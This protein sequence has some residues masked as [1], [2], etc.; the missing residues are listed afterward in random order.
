MIRTTFHSHR[1]W[2]YDTFNTIS[3]GMLLLLLCIRHGWN[4]M[5]VVVPV[6]KVTD[7][8]CTSGRMDYSRMVPTQRRLLSSLSSSSNRWMFRMFWWRHPHQYLPEPFVTSTRLYSTNTTNDVDDTTTSIKLRALASFI[9]MNMFESMLTAGVP[10][11]TILSR[12]EALSSLSSEATSTPSSP[13]IN[14][15][16]NNPTTPVTDNNDN[17]SN[18]VVVDDDDDDVDDLLSGSESSTPLHQKEGDRMVA[19]QD[20]FDTTG[21]LASDDTSAILLPPPLR[22]NQ[23]NNNDENTNHCESSSSS[24]LLLFIPPIPSVVSTAFGRPLPVIQEQIPPLQTL[25]IHPS[26]TTTMNDIS[27]LNQ[28]TVVTTSTQ[29]PEKV[30][31]TTTITTSDD[32]DDDDI[33]NSMKMAIDEDPYGE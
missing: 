8:W 18:D 22:T 11:E 25:L 33:T 16:G 26:A 20:T 17:N 31:T 4:G 2:W 5:D 14:D 23:D 27:N 12:T 9:S 15:N 30:L 19:L 24:Q 28:A 29:H 21:L 7:A 1:S 3:L 6:V 10:I 13:D 32:D